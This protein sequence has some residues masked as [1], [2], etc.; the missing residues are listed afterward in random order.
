[1]KNLFGE[2]IVEESKEDEFDVKKKAIP[3]FD[4]IKLMFSNPSEFSKKTNYEK[5]K[6]FFM[7]NRTFAIK[8]PEIADAFNKMGI[9]NGSVVQC[10]CNLLS[11]IY[12]VQPR[13]IWQTMNDVKKRKKKEET[14]KP[15]FSDDAVSMYC[16]MNMMSRRDF[17]MMY[18]MFPEETNEE[19]VDYENYV[20]ASF[21]KKK[22]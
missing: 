20:N 11:P 21:E 2:E 18:K 7:I 4:D 16:K 5:S 3:F 19:M 6:N 12:K 14:K 1:M 10:W 8:H 17:D 22:G 13:W 9:D 15:K